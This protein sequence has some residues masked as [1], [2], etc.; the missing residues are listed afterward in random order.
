MISKIRREEIEAAW[1][2]DEGEIYRHLGLAQMGTRSVLEARSSLKKVMA[3]AASERIEASTKSL[4]LSLEKEGKKTFKDA[5]KAIKGIVCK[6]YCM[7]PKVSG[8]DLVESLVG[9]AAAAVSITSA[10]LILVVTL[11]VKIGL[12]KLCNC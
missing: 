10:I 4:S 6:V 1:K 12:T 11:A 5:W 2:M 9:V 8:K 7:K 3:A